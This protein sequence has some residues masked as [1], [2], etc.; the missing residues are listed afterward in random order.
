MIPDAV[1]RTVET[2]GRRR[3]SRNLGNFVTCLVGHC[4]IPGCRSMHEAD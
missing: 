3:E 1:N 2:I 4:V